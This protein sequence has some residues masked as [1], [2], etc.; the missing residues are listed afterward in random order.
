MD[1]RNQPEPMERDR[2]DA[3]ATRPVP[4][5][6][7]ELRRNPSEMDIQEGQERM[8]EDPPSPPGKL[9]DYVR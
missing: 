6:D 2:Q 3:Q 5:P 7:P 8:Q 1:T 4:Q 9:N